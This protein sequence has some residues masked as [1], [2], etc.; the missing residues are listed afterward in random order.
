MSH[1]QP[2]ILSLPGGAA[3]SSFRIEKI[4][5]QARVAGLAPGRIATQYWHFVE[6]DAPLS[7]HEQSVLDAALSYA[8]RVANIPFAQFLL[9]TP[10]FGTVSP[11]SS[12][13]TDILHNCGLSK[14]RRIERG[15]AYHFEHA[16]DETMLLPLIHDRMTETVLRSVDEAAGLFAHVPPRELETVDVLGGGRHALVEANARL[17]LALSVDEI[18]YLADNFARMGRN[19]TDVELMMFAQANSEH[20]RHK[21]FNAAWVVDGIEQDKSLFRM[22]RDTHART[23]QGTLSA[24]E[25]NAA[26]MQGAE[27]E[28]FYPGKDGK[29]TFSSEPTHILMK[30]ETHNHP[31]AISPFP[32]AATGSGGEIRDEGAT[33]RGS[34]PKAGL[35]GFSVSN[36]RIPDAIQPWEEEYYGRPDRIVSPLAI[37]L[38]SD[39]PS[40][41]W[42]TFGGSFSVV[43]CSSSSTTQVTFDESISYSLVKMPRVQTPVVTE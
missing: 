14:V 13:A 9:V 23:P 34:K 7:P 21:I 36:L 40:G 18:D 19:P 22:I 1:A 16:A 26:V 41:A 27:I 24:Y 35:A 2:S 17:G 8:D 30:V 15:V 11:W 29:Y 6:L 43:T 31:T 42:T 37:M 28:R 20:C 25:D 38:A 33:G 12:K 39:L 10:R 5:D 32:G 3:L 4:H